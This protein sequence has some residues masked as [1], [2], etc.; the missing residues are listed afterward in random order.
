MKPHADDILA[1]LRE[2]PVCA[3]SLAGLERTHCPECGAD[4]AA[5]WKRRGPRKQARLVIVPL[6]VNAAFW[7]IL[8]FLA[9]LLVGGEAQVNPRNEPV[10]WIFVTIWGVVCTAFVLS[11]VRV[12]WLRRALPREFRLCCCLA[13]VPFPLALLLMAWVLWVGSR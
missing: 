5:E 9:G 8:T 1:L 7:T 11:L 6:G 4:I 3:Y 2:C 13:W 12:R 10:Y